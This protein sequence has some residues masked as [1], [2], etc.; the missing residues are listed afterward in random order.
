MFLE[1]TDEM[2]TIIEAIIKDIPKVHQGNKL[3]AQRVRCAT[4]ELSKVTK[5]WRKLSLDE[6][7][8]KKKK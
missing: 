1:S 4:I 3:A 2:S 5:Q 7:K 6:Q 8:K